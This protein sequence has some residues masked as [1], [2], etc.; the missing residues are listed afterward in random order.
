MQ[1]ARAV[2]PLRVGLLL[3]TRASDAYTATLCDWLAE[4]GDLE[5]A[6][7]LV[8][9]GAPPGRAGRKR[10]PAAQGPTAPL[11]APQPSSRT[12]LLFAGVMALEHQLLRHYEAHRAHLDLVDVAAL[13]AARGVP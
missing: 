8:T 2:K 12:P 6:L 7:V 11:T 3:E 13:A 5:L 9:D 4:H 1:W 10:R